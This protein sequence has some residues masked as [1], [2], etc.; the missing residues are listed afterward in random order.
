[1]EAVVIRATWQPKEGFALHWRDIEGKRAQM[2][3]KVWRHP[4]VNLENWPDPKLTSKS[5]LIKTMACGLCGSDVALA[6][7]DSSGYVSYPYMMSSPIIPGHEVSGRVVAVGKKVDRIIPGDPVT[8]QCVINCFYCSMC[9]YGRYDECEINEEL[10]FTVNGGCAEYFVVREDYVYSLEKLSRRFGKEKL[11]L[12]GSLIEPLTGTYKAL[13]DHG[14]FQIDF[15]VR[16]KGAA[17]VLGA[18]P[19][20]ISAMLNIKAFGI[21][22]VI[23][24]E[25]SLERREY[26]KLLGADVVL[27][28]VSVPLAETVLEITKNYGV[29]FVFEAS[30]ALNEKVWSELY[31]LFNKQKERP[32]LIFFG[33]SK[34]DLTIN[35]QLFIQ[36][37][38]VFTGSHG[39]CGV[40]EEV[41]DKVASGEI[42]DPSPMITRKISLAEAPLW[43]KNLATTKNEL[44]VTACNFNK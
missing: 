20:G 33:Q 37:Y 11:Y 12:V 43:L 10:G 34:K 39:H 38:A 41:I 42:A 5:V 31:S 17:L 1:M 29:L 8:V 28:P 7:E 30:G 22:K 9:K 27:D 35:P 16:K 21:G 13:K 2:A 24:S 4:R 3:N 6:N 26:A 40:W 23:I 18:G 32:R 25:P 36:R 14:I 44:K 19:I 15:R